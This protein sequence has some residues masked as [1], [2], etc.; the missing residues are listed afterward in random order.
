MHHN[1]AGD[2][3]YDIG[4]YVVLHPPAL[5]E[6]P[7]PDDITDPRPIEIVQIL[8]IDAHPNNLQ[9]Y[10]AYCVIPMCDFGREPHT[11]AG[12]DFEI[13]PGTI[14][15]LATEQELDEADYNA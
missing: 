8:Q 12:H 10:R 15:R 2:L 3:C 14:H 5:H 4:D 13:R 1:L 11:R 7:H 9:W 6:G